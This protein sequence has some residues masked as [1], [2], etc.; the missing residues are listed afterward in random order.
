MLIIDNELLQQ[1]YNA[2][3]KEL[4]LYIYSLCRN[5]NMSED[6]LQE[7]F[8]KA[9]LSLPEQHANMR[10]WLYMVA[11][12]LCFN[13]LKKEKRQIPVDK[14]TMMAK[15]GHPDNSTEDVLENLIRQEQNHRLYHA[16][17]KL[18]LIK[19]EVLELQYFSRLPLKEVA[20]ILQI[21]SENARVIS[22][23]AK[24]DLRKYLEDD[25]Y[26]I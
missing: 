21:S 16:M 7:T 6:L 5:W 20:A 26:E 24:R 8:V 15:Y 11:R 1:L 23:R 22:H 3:G 14:D 19:R 4:L 17:M 25:G 2:Y 9:L 13:A 12:N 10:A 18:P